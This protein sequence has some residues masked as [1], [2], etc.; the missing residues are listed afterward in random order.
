MQEKNKKINFIC[1]YHKKVVILQP[2]KKI[3][4]TC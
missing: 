2:N 4:N 1:V 3:L